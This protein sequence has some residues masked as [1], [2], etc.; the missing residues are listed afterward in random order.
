LVDFDIH[1]FAEGLHLYAER[2]PV[3][4]D[5]VLPQIVFKEIQLLRESTLGLSEEVICDIPMTLPQ[6]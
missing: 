3:L 5:V 2:L 4:G 1:A 6:S